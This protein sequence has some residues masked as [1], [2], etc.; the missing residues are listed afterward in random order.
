MKN[1]LTGKIE[2]IVQSNIDD[3]RGNQRDRIGEFVI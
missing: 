1:R 3:I 2:K